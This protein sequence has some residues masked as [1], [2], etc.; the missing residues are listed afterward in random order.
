[1][2]SLSKAPIQTFSIGFEHTEYNEAPQAKRVAEFLK[3]NHHEEIL[4]E[5]KCLDIV[6]T[7][8]TFYDEPFA[9]SSQIPTYLVSALAKKTVTVV[10]SG[11]GGDELF[12]GYNRYKAAHQLWNTITHLPKGLRSMGASTLSSVPSGFFNSI[13]TLL[14]E[15]F[16]QSNLPHKIEKIARI[17]RASS[18]K[19]FYQCLVTQ[20]INLKK[21]LTLDSEEHSLLPEIKR[22]SF[23]ENMQYWDMKTYLPDDILVKVDRATM[24]VGLEARV[25]LLDHR[26]VEFSWSLPEH[27]K[28]NRGDTKW[29][30]KQLLYKKMPSHLFSG[31]KKGFAVPIGIWLKGPLKKWAEDMIYSASLD[32]IN[33]SHIQQLWKEHVEGK[34]DHHE[35][36]WTYLIY[37]QWNASYR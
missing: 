18:E 26:L 23:I 11:D 24:A 10:L 25:P 8:A 21:L 27:F 34:Q 19:E 14:P 7:L 22:L 30:L 5:K 9:D 28:I 31:P 35:V 32:Q 16:S 36:L 15:K 1:M 12:G 33:S 2:Q 37:A 20:D 4:T 6:P 17:L 3:T 29:I 13:N